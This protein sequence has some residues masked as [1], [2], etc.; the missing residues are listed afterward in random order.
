MKDKT[1]QNRKRNRIL[2][3]IVGVLILALLIFLGIRYYYPYGEGVK[4]GQLN[5]VVYKGVIFKTYEG[6]L[7]QSG[8]WSNEPGGVQ[9][10]EFNFSIKDPVL[11]DSLMCLGGQMVELHYKEYFGRLPWRGHSRYIVDGIVNVTPVN[12]QP[13][14]PYP[15]YIPE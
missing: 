1:E 8:F 4:T 5:F 15:P 3:I 6:K 13:I 7:I 11:A 2:G 9:S 12:I 10:N 14:D